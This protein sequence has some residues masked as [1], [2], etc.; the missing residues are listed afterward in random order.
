[1]RKWAEEPGYGSP[2]TTFHQENTV[3]V[4]KDTMPGE[5]YPACFFSEPQDKGGPV[6]RL[7]MAV[8]PVRS[9]WK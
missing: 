6:V 4:G 2:Q 8:R 5:S 7:W 3:T 1:M 9:E